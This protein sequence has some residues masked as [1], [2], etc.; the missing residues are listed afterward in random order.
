MTIYDGGGD[1]SD[2]EVDPEVIE[3]DFVVKKCAGKAQIK[4]TSLV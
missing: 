3:D 1:R 2:Q 4:Y